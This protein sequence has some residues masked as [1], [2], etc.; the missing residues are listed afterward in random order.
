MEHLIGPLAGGLFKGG[1]LAVWIIM[2]YHPIPIQEF[3]GK[4]E[5]ILS[6]RRHRELTR[7]LHLHF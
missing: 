3:G 6:T 1:D 4:E 5:L 7:Y 2:P